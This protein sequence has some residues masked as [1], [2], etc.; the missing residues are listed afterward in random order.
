MLESMN[1][2][3]IDKEMLAAMKKELLSKIIKG[4]VFKLN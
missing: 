3:E 2:Y 4:C 1:I